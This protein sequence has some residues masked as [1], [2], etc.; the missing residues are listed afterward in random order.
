MRKLI[1]LVFGVCCLVIALSGIAA[2]Q[3]YPPGGGDGATASQGSSGVAGSG[4][5]GSSG[6]L[7]TTGSSGTS[8]LVWVGAGLAVLGGAL[9]IT[10]SR[11]RAHLALRT[12]S[13]G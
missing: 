4:V 5:A 9:V 6:S 13:L 3:A 11:R 10:A 1:V 7:P 12:T 2:A 8:E